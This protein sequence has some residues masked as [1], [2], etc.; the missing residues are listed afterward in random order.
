[1]DFGR[2]V[3]AARSRA[4]YSQQQLADMVGV[5]RST[6]AKWETRNHEPSFT[7]IRRLAR[8]LGVA[9]G[10]LLPGLFDHSAALAIPIGGTVEMGG[11]LSLTGEELKPA[12]IF[13]PGS[14][15]CIAYAIADDTMSPAY[16]SGDFILVASQASRP[17]EC[18]GRDCLV[19]LCS[20]HEIFRRLLPGS[21]NGCFT[22]EAYHASAMSDVP[23][24]SCRPVRS[25]V[26]RGHH[27]PS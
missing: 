22:L 23:V 19:E 3:E 2:R 4:G 12:G 7:T 25:R 20:G 16:R 8:A 5:S 13:P 15:E 18:L 27:Q 10:E 11:C 9:S 1:M 14:D 21:R 6:V 26:L 24:T 17:E